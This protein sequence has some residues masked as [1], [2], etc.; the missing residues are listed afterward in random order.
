[1]CARSFCLPYNCGC[2]FLFFI[3]WKDRLSILSPLII[4]CSCRRRKPYSYIIFFS[5]LSTYETLISDH[6]RL[7]DRISLVLIVTHH[8]VLQH[9]LID[10]IRFICPLQCRPYTLVSLGL[11]QV[12]ASVYLDNTLLMDVESQGG[13]RSTR[14]F[15]KPGLRARH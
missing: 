11:I 4:S 7:T 2:S 14:H 3:I 15:G 13:S 1:M 5:F 12:T 6:D 9:D 10:H 8:D